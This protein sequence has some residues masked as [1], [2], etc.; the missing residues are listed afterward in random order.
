MKNSVVSAWAIC[1]PAAMSTAKEL[2][3]SAGW[4]ELKG[5]DVFIYLRMSPTAAIEFA[6]S[7]IKAAQSN[8]RMVVD[9]DGL[10]E[11]SL[12]DK[13]IDHSYGFYIHPRGA[14]LSIE[15]ADMGNI[16]ELLNDSAAKHA[17]FLSLEK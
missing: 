10:P 12:T 7:L 9:D 8:C 16:D 5:K 2:P 15:I 4:K 13:P 14:G 3:N 11:G 1:S 17:S 6:N